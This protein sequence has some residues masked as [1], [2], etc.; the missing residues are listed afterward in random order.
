[1]INDEH[2]IKSFYDDA[3][4][5]SIIPTNQEIAKYRLYQCDKC[6]KWFSFL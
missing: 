4:N 2:F 5:E 6:Y 1:M 3:F